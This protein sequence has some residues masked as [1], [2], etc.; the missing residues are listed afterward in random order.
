MSNK[1][2]IPS[3]DSDFYTW[4]QKMI[5]YAADNSIRWRVSEPGDEMSNLVTEF[6]L[7]LQAWKAPNSGKIDFIT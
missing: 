2:Y 1:K 4:A 5:S 7:A 6:D 3:K